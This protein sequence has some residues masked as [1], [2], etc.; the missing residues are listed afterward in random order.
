[1]PLGTVIGF[2]LIKRNSSLVR[3]RG[4]CTPS[5]YTNSGVEVRKILA[6]IDAERMK[7]IGFYY[8][9]YSIFEEFKTKKTY[10]LI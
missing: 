3:S 7:Y 10:E 8:L 9:P 4:V 2:V 5:S 6:E 1:M